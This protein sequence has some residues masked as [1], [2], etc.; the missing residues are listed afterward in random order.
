MPDTKSDLRKQARIR[1]ETLARAVPDFAT[2]IAAH[3]DALGIPDNTLI[4]AYVALPGEADPHQL[5]KQLILRGCTIAFPCVH[6][7]GEPLVFHRWQPGH[8]FIK[9]AY[10]IPE[11]AL[12]WP[13]AYP[14]ILLVPLLAFDR[15]GHRLGYGGGFYDRTIASLEP[16]QTIGVAYADQEVEAL[17]HEPHDIPLDM[18][19]TEQ[20]VRRF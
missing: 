17:P 11:P 13:V 12:D 10:G 9:G 6:A 4:G 8:E 15:Q 7:K 18:V 16:A 20:G 3:I 2:R 5:L 19:I 1:R 14:R